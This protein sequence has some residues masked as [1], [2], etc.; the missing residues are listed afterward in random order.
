MFLTLAASSPSWATVSHMK[1]TLEVQ[2]EVM[3]HFTLT[4]TL[5]KICFQVLGSCGCTEVLLIFN[6]S[7]SNHHIK[8]ILPLVFLFFAKLIELFLLVV[9]GNW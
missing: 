6:S 1:L 8:H 5:F 3:N 9:I 4:K 7:R 2:S